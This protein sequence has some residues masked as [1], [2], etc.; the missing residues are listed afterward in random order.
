MTYPDRRKNFFEGM[1]DGIPI[2]LGYLAVAFAL[3]ITARNAGINAAEGFL[4]SFINIA[5]AGE[6][7][8][9]MCIISRATVL[10]TLL[11]ILVTNLR[12]LLM[13]CS[14]SQRLNPGMSLGH[15]LLVGFGLTD[16]IFGISMAREGFLNPYY[17]YGAMAVS[18][19]M[20]S[21]GTALGIVM[22]N[23][24]PA[25][26]VSALSVALFGM[27]IALIIPEG[28]RNRIVLAII[29]VSFAASFLLSR[30]TKISGGMQVVILTIVIST[31]AAVL[32][33]LK[34][35]GADE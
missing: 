13:S 17:S 8:G 29:C 16:E 1:R 20:W 7:A 34:E 21:I 14:M 15:R 4:M 32:F 19:P 31:L 26:V 18:I 35:G 10:G 25:R 2:G 12:Y 22:G 30:L 3:G 9:I 28:K 23:V 5:S 27:F 33:P 24:L 11:T 6:Y